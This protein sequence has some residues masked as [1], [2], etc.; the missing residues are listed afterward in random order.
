MSGLMEDVMME[1]GRTTTCTV[2]GSTHGRMV[3]STR[4]S[5]LMTAN[6]GMVSTFG[7]M[8]ANTK[9]FGKTENNMERVLINR[10]MD[11]N[12]AEFGRMESVSSGWM[13]DLIF[14]N[15]INLN[16]KIQIISKQIVEA[17]IIRLQLATVL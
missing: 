17:S 3:E 14:D 8:V 2:V 4:E 12:A 13:S 15:L 5:T 1:T 6:T 9:D 10:Q 11:R 7:K 16:L